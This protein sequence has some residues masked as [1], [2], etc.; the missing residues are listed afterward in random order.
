MEQFIHH[1]LNKYM[2]E[3]LNRL[4]RVL[5]GHSMGGLIATHLAM[6]LPANFFAA[7]VLSGPAYAACNEPCTLTKKLVSGVSR[8]LPK[9]PLT[10][11]S[12][13]FVSHNKAVVELVKN[14]PFYCN[15]PLR[16]RFLHE[17]LQ[18]QCEV[19]ARVK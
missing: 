8:C 6:R 16:A 14:D 4:P 7:V 19:F 12:A 13:S 9:L 15:A 18:A 10:H 5:I 1:I 2:S 17:L 11:I 3:E